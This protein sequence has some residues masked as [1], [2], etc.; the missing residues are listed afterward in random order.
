MLRNPPP[1]CLS[2]PV[3]PERASPCLFCNRLLSESRCP[4]STSPLRPPWNIHT[5]TQTHTQTDRP[6]AAVR[7][8]WTETNT[9]G[10]LDLGL[11]KQHALRSSPGKTGKKV[12]GMLLSLI[13]KSE[14]QLSNI[15][16]C[17]Y[18]TIICKSWGVASNN[19]IMVNSV[20]ISAILNVTMPIMFLR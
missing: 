2:V 8:R 13:A 20:I 1:D 11:R 17:V 10:W 7:D 15:R 5:H 14:M 3:S 4:D 9:E 19:V 16:H 18:S 12:H 6:N